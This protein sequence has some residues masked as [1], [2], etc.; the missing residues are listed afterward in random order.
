MTQLTSVSSPLS[1]TRPDFAFVLLWVQSHCAERVGSISVPWNLVH[2]LS[3]VSVHHEVRLESWWAHS[4]DR[5]NWCKALCMQ[6]RY[7]NVIGLYCAQYYLDK[8]QG[9][10]QRWSTVWVPELVVKCSDC[11]VHALVE[12]SNKSMSA[13]TI[14]QATRITGLELRLL[15]ISCKKLRT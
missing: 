5:S 3:A 4:F 7:W 13:L 15:L 14:Q 2:I 1:V 9:K 8:I 10:P 12:V 6:K 11:R